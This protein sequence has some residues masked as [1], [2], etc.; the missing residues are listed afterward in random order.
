MGRLV[1]GIQQFNDFGVQHFC[2]A[3][4]PRFWNLTLAALG[5]TGGKY[6]SFFCHI[7]SK[8]AMDRFIAYK[9]VYLWDLDGGR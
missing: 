2:C 3:P 6:I 4:T 9:N 5:T 8:Y 7:W 1:T